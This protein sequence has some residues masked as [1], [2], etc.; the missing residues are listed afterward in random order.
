MAPPLEVLRGDHDSMRV[1]FRSLRCPSSAE[2][3]KSLGLRESTTCVLVSIGRIWTIRGP[4]LVI[5]PMRLFCRCFR[6]SRWNSLENSNIFDSFKCVLKDRYKDRMKRIKI[7]YGKMARNDGKPVPLGHCTYYEGMHNY[8]PR[9][10]TREYKWRK[11]SKIAHQ[12]RKVADANGWT[13][14][15]TA[16]DGQKNTEKTLQTIKMMRGYGWKFNLGEK[17]RRRVISMA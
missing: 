8:H 6:V 7:K 15:H 5:F 11:N 9:A 12:N 14:R 17:E 16:G 10:R 4:D 2:K 13:A 3:G 1:I